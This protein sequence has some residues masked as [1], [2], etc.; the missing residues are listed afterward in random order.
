MDGYFPRGRNTAIRD[1]Y[2]HLINSRRRVEGEYYKVYQ[3]PVFVLLRLK[4]NLVAEEKKVFHLQPSLPVDAER[5]AR[6][7]ERVASREIVSGQLY[8]P[9]GNQKI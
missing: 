9:D 7:G 5:S 3:R 4:Q 2:L 1:K 6:S 8:L